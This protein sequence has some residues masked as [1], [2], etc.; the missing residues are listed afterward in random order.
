M[1]QGY[2][3]NELQSQEL[4]KKTKTETVYPA[5]KSLDPLKVYDFSLVIQLFNQIVDLLTKMHSHTKNQDE[6][7][8]LDQSRLDMGLNIDNVINSQTYVNTILRE[9][10]IMFKSYLT[11]F[12]RHHIKYLKRLDAKV[13][14]VLAI[15]HDDISLGSNKPTTKNNKKENTDKTKQEK[16]DRTSSENKAESTTKATAQDTTEDTTEDTDDATEDT[17]EDTAKGSA[18]DT[19]ENDNTN[20][21]EKIAKEVL[22][23]V[24]SK[25]EGAKKDNN[26]SVVINE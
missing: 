2:I 17:T 8:Q 22:N 10:G 15:I 9:K 19:A 25:L 4:I 14:L 7:L 18:E 24:I 12:Q 1:I 3:K 11:A 23:D 21:P 6:N 16:T 13:D 20:S 5:Y 26:I